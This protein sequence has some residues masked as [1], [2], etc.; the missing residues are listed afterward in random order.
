[1]SEAAL[2]MLVGL[3]ASGKSTFAEFFH[4]PIVSSDAIRLEMFGSEEDQDH[5]N[6][7]FNEVHRRIKHFLE[8]GVSVVYDATN[9]SRKRRRGFLKQLPA[10]VKK[11]A[12]I[13]ATEIDI[14]LE[15]NRLRA[16][17]VPEEVIM[18]MYRNMTLPRMDEGWDDIAVMP[19]PDNKRRLYDYLEDSFGVEH[20]NPH[21]SA[22]IF[23]HMREAGKIALELA[24]ERGFD[25]QMRQLAYIAAAHHDIGKPTVK[26]RM[27][28]NGVLDDKSHYYNHAEVGAYMAFSSVGVE[29]GEAMLQLIP[30]G[31]LIQWHMEAFA[32][33]EHYL[34]KIEEY[35]GSTFRKVFEV[36]HEADLR[37][38]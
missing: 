34:E 14:V 22:N 7:V 28:R 19:H 12:D 25:Y 30:V 4:L 37:A 18:R 27:K 36:V 13:V 23:D 35:H 17:H 29:V 8:E 21:H 10:N 31:M 9:L 6:E 1:M 5:N 26:S 32:D 33:P 11:V 15:Q 38:H 2:H 3:P 24:D 16:R 20:D